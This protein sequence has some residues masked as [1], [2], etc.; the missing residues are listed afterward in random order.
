MHDIFKQSEPTGKW[1]KR[2]FYQKLYTQLNP[3]LFCVD[4]ESMTTT[5]PGHRIIWDMNEELFL[6]NCMRDWTQTLSKWRIKAEFLV[7]L[8][9]VNVLTPHW[10]EFLGFYSACNTGC[11]TWT[12]YFSSNQSLLLLFKVGVLSKKAKNTD[13]IV[14]SLI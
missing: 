5:I 14:F 7:L 12:H 6:R 3:S 4:W 13:F 2:F 9:D 1:I 10:W 8:W 11:S